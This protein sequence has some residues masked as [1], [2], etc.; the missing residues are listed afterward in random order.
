MTPEA[1]SH[2]FK[3]KNGQ[4]TERLNAANKLIELR[5]VDNEVANAVLGA[6]EARE[7]FSP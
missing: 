3:I 7:Y 5:A 4:G 2:L 1:Y 6:I